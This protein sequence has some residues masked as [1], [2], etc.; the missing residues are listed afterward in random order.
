[1][2]KKQ[3]HGGGKERVEVQAS[4]I[5]KSFEGIDEVKLLLGGWVR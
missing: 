2:V 3:N 5:K 1:M 4:E